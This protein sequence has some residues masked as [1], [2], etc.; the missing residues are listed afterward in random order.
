MQALFLQARRQKSSIF[1]EPNS[2]DT[3]QSVVDLIAGLTKKRTD[4]VA[5]YFQGKRLEYTKARAVSYSIPIS[6]SCA[7]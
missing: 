1:L 3:V 6:C 4:D 7:V 2:A 5:L